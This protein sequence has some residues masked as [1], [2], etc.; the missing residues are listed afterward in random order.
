MMPE[1]AVGIVI[2]LVALAISLLSLFFSWRTYER[3][4]N[5]LKVTA[6]FHLES[7]QG[8]AF[9]VRL[10]NRGRRPINVESLLLRLKSG[11]ALLPKPV[12][13]KISLDENETYEHW[14]SLTYYRDE[15]NSPLVIKEAEAYDT[16]GKK[17]TFPFSKLKKQISKEWTPE[18]DWLKR[19]KNESR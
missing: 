11:K 12:T 9:Q 5:D 3:D 17:Y 14:F 8:T 7:E 16:H 13:P 18:N 10:V 1:V 15:I 4:R 6:T 19:P 2:S